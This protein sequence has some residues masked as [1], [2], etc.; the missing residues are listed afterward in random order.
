MS[1]TA[2]LP[3]LRFAISLGLALTGTAAAAADT[4]AKTPAAA[5]ARQQV[6]AL[7]IGLDNAGKLISAT[8]LD[9]STAPAMNQAALEIARK[10]P[11]APARKGGR[12]VPSETTLTLTM[13]LEPRG[14]AF[15][16]AL[17]R[18]QNGPSVVHMGKTNSPKVPEN[19]GLVLVSVDLGA[20]GKPDMSTFKVERV[21][22]RVPSSFA[23]QRYSDAARNTM[24]GTVFQ[25]DKVDG[26]ETPAR[27]TVP[28][29]FNGGARKMKPGE[30][31]PKP[32][33]K[34]H[35]SAP[36]LSE[37]SRIEGVDLPKIDFTAPEK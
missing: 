34:E 36:S 4:P 7:R 3:A 30:D 35:D 8:N 6:I 18:A 1:P 15:A 14:D 20:D 2:R 26:I 28:F 24:K 29:M 33:E 37:V 9:P 25:L 21:D 31:E 12:A 22:L 5:P 19:G 10:L 27:I 16:I 17:K 23:E 32:V 11:Y 13:A